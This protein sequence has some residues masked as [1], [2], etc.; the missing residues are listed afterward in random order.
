MCF[1]LG[2]APHPI[3]SAPLHYG[4]VLAS[5]LPLS[6]QSLCHHHPEPPH[7]CPHRKNPCPLPCP[8]LP[9]LFSPTPSLP[10]PRPL[11]LLQPPLL[12]QSLSTPYSALR[13][14]PLPLTPV[15]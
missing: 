1:L 5:W 15:K 14:A 6:H 8:I 12:L 9:S 7:L 13:L 10:F 11:V 3:P 4:G 2:S